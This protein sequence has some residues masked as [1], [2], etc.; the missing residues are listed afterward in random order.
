V[1]VQSLGTLVTNLR[2][3]AGHS[4]S[5]ATG[6]NMRDQLVYLLNR[7]QEELALDYDWPGLIVD[8]DTPLVAGTRY[9]SYPADLPFDNI[10]NAWLVWNTLYGELCYG[11]GPDE[12][13]VFNSNTGFTSWPVQRWMHNSDMNLFE[14]WPIPS[15][16]PPA[17]PTSQAALVRFRGTRQI[18]WMV[19]D[20]DQCVLPATVITLFAAAELLARQKSP[21]AGLKLQKAQEYIRRYRVRQSAHKTKPFVVAGGQSD[22]TGVRGQRI[23]LDYIPIGYGNGPG[24]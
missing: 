12:F 5:P 8:R 19:A 22:G 11:I 7:T 18:P 2:L 6:I 13:A 23:G 20:S 9:Y 14:L 21:D 3:E 24:R 16:A 10:T 15:E 17:T 4:S 1:A